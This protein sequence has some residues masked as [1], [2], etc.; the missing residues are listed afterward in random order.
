MTSFSTL[1]PHPV[2]WTLPPPCPAQRLPGCYGGGGPGPCHRRPGADGKLPQQAGAH[3]RGLSG[4]H[5]AGHQP[6]RP[7]AQKLPEGWGNL[8]VIVDNK[9]GAGA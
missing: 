9:P 4:G 3:H 2:P 8:G 7:L 5:G 1:T 6:A